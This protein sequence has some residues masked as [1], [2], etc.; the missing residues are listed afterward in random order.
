[1]T[2]YESRVQQVSAAASVEISRLDTP[3]VLEEKLQSLNRLWADIARKLGIVVIIVIIIKDVIR[4]CRDIL[5]SQ[6]DKRIWVVFLL[7]RRYKELS[8]VD[9]IEQGLTSHQTHYR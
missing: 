3:K 5:C 4:C 6:I 1:L 9:W 7:R 8:G 2:S